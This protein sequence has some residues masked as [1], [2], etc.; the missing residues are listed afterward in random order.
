MTVNLVSSDSNL[1]APVSPCTNLTVGVVGDP[2][3]GQSPVAVDRRLT[4]LK[5]TTLS[6]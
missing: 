3:T 5:G 1:D 2:V 6:A 4:G